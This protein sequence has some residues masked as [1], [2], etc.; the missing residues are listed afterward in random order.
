MFLCPIKLQDRL[1]VTEGIRRLY[2]GFREPAAELQH[3][4]RK[5]GKL[6][7]SGLAFD[8]IPGQQLIW[9]LSTAARHHLKLQ[10]MARGAGLEACLEVTAESSVQ[11][12]SCCS[13]A[14]LLVLR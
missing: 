10:V 3:H 12:G 13:A 2:H 5:H 7:G 4:N 9:S 11:T 6:N 14:I 8:T 1:D